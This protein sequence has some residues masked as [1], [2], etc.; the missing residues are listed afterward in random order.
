MFYTQLG[1]R[2][3]EW[4]SDIIFSLI[5]PLLAE[6]DLSTILTN[7]TLRLTFEWFE[8]EGMYVLNTYRKKGLGIE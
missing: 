3:G 8:I 6:I 2:V 4:N 7:Q 5:F 1:T